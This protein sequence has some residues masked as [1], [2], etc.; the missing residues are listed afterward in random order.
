MKSQWSEHP[1]FNIDESITADNGSSISVMKK[2][3]KENSEFL[4]GV[5]LGISLIV[6]AALLYE[7]QQF[8]TEERLKQYDLDWFK[9]HEFAEVKTDV[10]VTK[11]LVAAKCSK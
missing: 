11:A 7:Y 3:V 1:Y 8:K 5:L 10:T 9:T 2:F 4:L 6:N